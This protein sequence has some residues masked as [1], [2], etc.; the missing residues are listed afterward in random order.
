MRAAI[1]ARYSSDLQSSASID[2]QVRICTRLIDKEGWSLVK[3]YSDQGISGASHLRAGYQ[4]MLNDARGG[5]FDVVVAESIDRLSRDQEHIASVFKLLTFRQIPLVTVAEGMIS[6]LHIGLKGTM[7]ALF[8]KD[9]AQKTH[10]GLEG[11]IRCGKS[12]GGK[13]YGY[14]VVRTIAPHGQIAA[15][16][17]SINQVQAEIIGGIFRSFAAGNSPRTIAADLNKRGIAGPSNAAWGA[18]T[19]HGNWRR[20]TGILNNELYIGRLVW[21]RQSFVKDPETGKRQAR[22]NLEADWILEEVPHLRIL[23]DALWQAVKQ[24]QERT[25]K[26]V[27]QKDRLHSEQARRPKY[28]F[29]GLLRCGKCGGGYVLVGK[30]H[31]GC[32]N[33][34]NK[35]TCDNRLTIRRDIL[36]HTVLSGLREQLLHPDLVAEYTSAYL[37]EWN[38]LQIEHAATYKRDA[39]ELHKVERQIANIIEAVKQGLFA[40]SMK[41]ELES[42]EQRKLELDRSAPIQPDATPLLHPGLAQNYRRQ[43]ENLT[44]ALGEDA[45]RVEAAEVIRSLIEEIR[46]VPMEDGLVIELVG[47]LASILALGQEQKSPLGKAEG[48]RQITLV[49]G[50]GFEPATF[51]L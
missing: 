50:A 48:A 21:N 32:A 11:R 33:V 24:R 45:M 2:D 40:P 35:G 39:T 17:R 49:A 8:L 7:S 20:G 41:A 19:I 42:L 38:R 13:S 36:E 15:G 25:R 5:L 46:M 12:A 1:Y 16:E 29:S 4:Q 10:R 22:P 3:V 14:D 44:K 31:F 23:D 9:L 28:L 34:K 6:E 47:E 27:I 30:T 51:R 26:D 37:K 43:V 18:S